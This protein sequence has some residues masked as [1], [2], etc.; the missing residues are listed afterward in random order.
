MAKKTKTLASVPSV[1]TMDASQF[2]ILTDGNGGVTKIKLSDLKSAM[3][4]G[5]DLDAIEDGVFVMFHRNSDDYPLAVRPD[6][7]TN[8]QNSGEIAEGV[9]IV[10]GG[11]MLV[12]SPTEATLTWSSA[13]VA[14][15]GTTT[16]D[17]LTALNDWTGKSST[18]AQITHPECNTESYAPGFC[19]AYSRV[20]ANGKGLTAGRWWLPS[21]GEMMMIFANMRKINYALSLINGAAQLQENWYWTSTESSSAYAWGLHLSYGSAYAWDSKASDQGRVRPVSAFLN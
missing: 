19:A 13:A 8:Y 17:R 20:N 12:V 10:E 6:Q 2:L 9:M 1:V 15:G 14:G 3:L 4:G 11:K 21:L 5:T 16:S 7:W 18:A